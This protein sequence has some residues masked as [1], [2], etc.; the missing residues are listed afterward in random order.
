MANEVKKRNEIPLEHTWDTASVF[1]NDAAWETE[2][3]WITDQIPALAQQ[4]G[5]LK[6]ANALEKFFDT[7]EEIGKRLGKVALYASMFYTT[8]TSDQRAAAMNDRAR[9]LGARVS[10]AMAFAEPELLKIGLPKLRQWM[11]KNARLKIFAHYFDR[12]Y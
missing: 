6:S 12:L 5:K 7:T 9:G 11:K 10:A 2:F 8:D 1:P 3:K 4:R